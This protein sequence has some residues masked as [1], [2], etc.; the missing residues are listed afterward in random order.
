MKSKLKV[1]VALF[2]LWR[3]GLIKKIDYLSLNGKVY[4]NRLGK[5]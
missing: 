4:I 3:A 5:K 2:R 1:Y